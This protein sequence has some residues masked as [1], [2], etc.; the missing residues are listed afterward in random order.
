MIT[1]KNYAAI[2]IGSN[3]V[4][5]LVSTITE[6]K[7][8]EETDFR[9]TSLVRVPIRLGEDVFK[10]SVISENN[11]ERMVDTMQ[12]FNLLMKSHGIVEY[13]ACAT[14]AMREAKN[15]AQVVEKIKAKT[16]VEIEIIDGNHE[17]AII[18]ATDL[19]ELIKNDCNYLYVDV[20]G[21]STEY[22]LYSSGKTVASRSFKVGTV[23]LLNNLVED[24]AW[25]EMEKWVKETTKPYKDIDLIGSGGNI[26]N[27]FKTSGKKEGK[28]LSL[29][30]IKK[31]NELLNSLSYEERVMDLQ[32]K[33]DRADV[34]IPASRIY[35]NSMKWAR[36]DNIFV[37]K[38]GLADGIIKSLYN[39][40]KK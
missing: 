39:G 12:A 34:I 13:K 36:A 1:Q 6:Q 3:A 25:E 8:R 37:P 17:A 22:T 11:I 20:G 7:G 31:Y 16:G 32:L 27:I 23:R 38:I 33:S 14:S 19:H 29:A 40:K 21:G 5:L 24:G 4:R 18:A 28:P 35:L 30:Y 10:Q 26:N 15:G 2:D 9:K